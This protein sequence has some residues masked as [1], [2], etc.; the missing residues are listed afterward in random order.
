MTNTVAQTNTE[1]ALMPEKERRMRLGAIFYEFLCDVAEW[2]SMQEI[3]SKPKVCEE[4][5]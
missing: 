1:S 5:A 2:Q 4:A 3:Q